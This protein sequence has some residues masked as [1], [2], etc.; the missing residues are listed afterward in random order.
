MPSDAF[1]RHLS[2]C[3]A[4]NKRRLAT[5]EKKEEKTEK[6]HAIITS[7][8]LDTG[9]AEREEHNQKQRLLMLC[10]EALE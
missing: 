6:K 4:D 10:R 7:M 8:G 5:T 2:D 3:E 1:P 9:K